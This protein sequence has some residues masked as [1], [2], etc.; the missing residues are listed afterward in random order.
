MYGSAC[1]R[2]TGLE[3]GIESIS[4]FAGHYKDCRGIEVDA[5]TNIGT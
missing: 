5:Y 1:V 3:L 2:M 4:L